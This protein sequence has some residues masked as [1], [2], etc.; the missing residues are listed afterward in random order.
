VTMRP[1]HHAPGVAASRSRPSASP[2]PPPQARGLV[3]ASSPIGPTRGVGRHCWER[4]PRPHSR[5]R[6]G[7]ALA[8]PTSLRSPPLWPSPPPLSVAAPW[9][10]PCNAAAHSSLR[11]F[12]QPM[13]PSTN[14]ASSA[15]TYPT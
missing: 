4:P 9:P 3:R 5:P 15:Q 2:T 7:Q 14:V 13:A 6:W 12:P 1:R 11:R 8:M 10:Q